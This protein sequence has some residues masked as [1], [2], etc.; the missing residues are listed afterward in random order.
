MDSIT[1]FYPLW[2]Y[3]AARLRQGEIP[4]WNPYLFLGAPF[5]ANL[6]AGVLYP[7][8]WIWLWLPAP[9]AVAY[10]LVSHIILAGVGTYFFSR[11]V[12]GLTRWGSWVAGALVS[13]GGYLGAQAEHVNQVSVFAWLPVLLWLWHRTHRRRGLSD[14]LWVSLALGLQFLAGHA[15][16]S[17]INLMALITYASYLAVQE[18]GRDLRLIRSQLTRLGGAML[19][20]IGLAAAQLIP[21]W[22]L[23]RHSLRGE[24]LSYRQAV[25]FSWPPTSILVSFLPG[26]ESSPFSEYIAYVGVVG[27]L[28]AAVG[29]ASRTRQARFFAVLSGLGLFLALGLYNP[30]YIVLYSVIPGF[31]LFRVPARWLFLFAFGVALMAGIG[32]DAWVGGE[33][34]SLL[35]AASVLTGS[36]ARRW[37]VVLFGFLSAVLIFAAT[38]PAASVV[39]LWIVVAIAGMALLRLKARWRQTALAGMMLAELFIAS[40]YLVYDRATAPEAYSSLRTSTLDLL[41]R[42]GIDR[43]LSISDTRF[44]PGDL[45]DIQTRYADRL[46]EQSILDLIVATKWKEVLAPNLGLAYGL[47]SVDGYDGGL[48]PT[49]RYVEFERLL[50]SSGEP[51]LDGR[52]Y[53]KLAELPPPPILSLLNVRYVLM[54]KL[55][56]VWV[57]GAYYD[58]GLRTILDAQHPVAMVAEVPA[59]SATAVAMLSYF[60]G[61]ASG[62]ESPTVAQLEITSQE[63]ARKIYPV[64]LGRHSTGEGDSGVADPLDPNKTLYRG[65]WRLDPPTTPSEI[66]VR[67]LQDQGR[68]IL[69][70]LALLDERTG[71][72]R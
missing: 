65:L 41:A 50:M 57:D 16:A 14:L 36:R 30:F 70:G 12:L 44:D 71:T 19:L 28:L 35:R 53:Q 67:Y 13:L 49:A 33:Q 29:L 47:P 58:L 1:Y 15:Q 38:K 56:D 18:G 37:V 8:N 5:L 21:T 45:G 10:A 24:G 46:S 66:R 51:S 20:G 4:L 42:G 68:F 9:K 39:V 7:L 62:L 3:A 34:R 43:V 11:R 69:R 40:R 55:R 25:S 64:Q 61:V 54:D 60:E 32:M 48:T 22:E 23:A 17:F 26:L 6:Q 2:D 72:H 52:L 31:S 27:L 63:G 59:F